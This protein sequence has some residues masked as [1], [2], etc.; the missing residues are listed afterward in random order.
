MRFVVNLYRKQLD[1]GRAFL[2]EQPATARSWGLKEVKGM[3]QEAGVDVMTADLFMYGL[4]TWG[5]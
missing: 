3:M 1:G 5:Q 4:K 2:H